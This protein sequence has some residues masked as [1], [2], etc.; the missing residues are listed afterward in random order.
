MNPI[1]RVVTSTNRSWNDANRDFRPDCDLLNPAANGECGAMSNRNF[2][3]PVPGS[4]YDPEIIGGW[5]HREYNWQFSAGVQHELMPRVALDA[6]YFRRWYGNFNVTD[7][8]AVTPAD[9]DEF[10][11]VSPAHPDLPGGGGR[12][13][14]GL[15]D[16][17]PAK[18]GVPADNLI[19]FAKH[20][21]NMTERW[22]GVDVTV[23]ARLRQGML[24]M[25]GLSTG[26]SSSD[27]CEIRAQLPETAPSFFWSPGAAPRAQTPETAPLT[28]YCRVQSAFLTQVKFIGTYTVPRVEVQ[29]S[30]VYQSLPGPEI[31]A[32]YTAP[33]AV[34]ART[35]GRP[36]S[37]GAANAT[38][39]LIEPGT[40][41]G[42]RRNQFDLR[43]GKI[44]QA[45]RTRT[46]A[47]LDL[48]NMFNANPV[49]AENSSFAVWR[50][51][52]TILPARFV[53]VSMVFDF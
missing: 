24:L 53:K 17:K 13:I 6:T 12:V 49:L 25:G 22:N 41:Y 29:V 37:G 46:T 42:E 48:Y 26:R 19:T 8:R 4:T 44:L 7:N 32:L 33:S 2:G 9:Y 28:P 39:N 18:F 20:Y 16:L 35:L 23:N 21:G 52:T 30:A 43:V 34:V 15:Y 1:D 31:A 38:V 47:N 5:G 27:T 11:I 45:A 50:R 14:G 36:L 40:M 10:S 51:P 3:L